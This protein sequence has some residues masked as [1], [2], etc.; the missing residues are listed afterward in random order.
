[1][2][3]LYE[4]AQT[5]AQESMLAFAGTEMTDALR[6]LIR[7]KITLAYTT[8]CRAAREEA[9]AAVRPQQKFARSIPCEI[10]R[11]RHVLSAFVMRLST[12]FSEM[13]SAA[14]ISVRGFPWR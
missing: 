11:S 6:D 12:R 1:M 9:G 14:A 2:Y 4:R 5:H 10:S 3:W 8:A 13:P 7:S